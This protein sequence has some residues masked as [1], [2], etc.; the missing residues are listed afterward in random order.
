MKPLALAVA[1]A[2][3]WLVAGAAA[4]QPTGVSLEAL[5]REEQLLQ[6]DRFDNDTAQVLGAQLVLRA[7]RERKTVT[8]QVM[9]GDA[10]LFAQAMPGA[11]PDH[12]DWIRRKNNLV[13]RTGHSSFYTHN[14]VRQNGGDHDALPG[15][16]M[17]DYAAHGGAFPIVVRGQGLVGTVTVSGLPGPDD[18][19]LVV[20]ALRDYL[21]VEAP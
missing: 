12:A 15:L 5:L 8:I 1:T 9:R 11:S 16:D 2:L 18:H 3:L 7:H 14:Q 4:A 13:K 20:A 21:N 6:F 17:R 19:A 10:V